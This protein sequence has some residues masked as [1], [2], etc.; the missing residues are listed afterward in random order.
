MAAVI[1]KKLPIWEYYNIY[2]E[3]NKLTVCFLG[4]NNISQGL[5]S[6]AGIISEEKLNSC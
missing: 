3:D 4:N 6:E 5:F 2:N 1:I